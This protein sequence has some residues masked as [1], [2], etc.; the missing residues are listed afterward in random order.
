MYKIGEFSKLSFVTVQAL[1]LYDEIGLFKPVKI[2]QLTGY[3]YYSAD[4]LLHINYIV[5]LKQLGLSLE[6][7]SVVFKDNLDP[8]RIK[9]LLLLK[10]SDLQRRMQEDQSKLN[11]VEKLL[12]R[13]EERG[14]MPRHQTVL[15][16]VEP[17]LVASVRAVIPNYSGQNIAGLFGELI[18]F[19]QKNELKFAGP[20][21]M[22]YCDP[23]FKEEKPDIEVAAVIN[24]NAADSEKVKIYELPA[25]EKAASV[26]YKG[27]YEGMG[28]AYNDIMFWI[29]SHN[30]KIEGLCRE[31]YLVS[32]GDTNDP[33]KYVSEIQ[34][35][36]VES[37]KD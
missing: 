5:G 37:V 8:E 27:S 31:L 2:D 19:I 11:N 12:L 10:R 18:G 30:Y 15:K 24:R 28:E 36:I 17:Q 21:M 33:E 26:T 1:R 9:Q 29:A 32:P 6:D 4:Q 22:I 34:I 14:Q 16:K 35:P 7:I 3:R 23:D 13:L 25:M 20:T